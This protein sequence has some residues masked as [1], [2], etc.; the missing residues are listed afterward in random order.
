MPYKSIVTSLLSSTAL[1][2]IKGISIA[3]AISVGASVMFSAPALSDCNN[4]NAVIANGETETVTQNLAEGDNCTIEAGGTIEVGGDD[5]TAILGTNNHTIANDGDITTLGINSSGIVVFD[6][7][8]IA[9]SGSIT[10]QGTNSFGIFAVEDNEISNT[11]TVTTQ[12]DLSAGILANSDNTI[13]NDG[14]I[15]TLGNNGDGIQ[16]ANSN[17]IVNAGTITTQGDDSRGIAAN[18][19][20]IITNMG[21][22]TTQGDLSIGIL[23]GSENAII[24]GNTI[25]TKGNNAFGIFAVNGNE[26]SNTGAITTEGIGSTGILAVVDNVIL[27]AG[28]ITTLAGDGIFVTDNNKITNT[29]TITSLGERSQ[30]IFGGQKNT[31]TNAGAIINQGIQGRGIAANVENIV[32]NTG[33]IT[34]QAERS[35]GIIAF[36]D[37]IVMN[38]GSIATQG[39]QSKGIIA[40]NGNRITNKGKVTSTGED[41]TLIKL[42]SFNTF[43]NGGLLS[44]TSHDGTELEF[45]LVVSD[46][47]NIFNIEQGHLLIGRLGV[48][49]DKSNLSLNFN[50]NVSTVL[51]FEKGEQEV[52]GE[53]LNFA[54]APL[55]ENI[56]TSGFYFA[57]NDTAVAVLDQSGLAQ[58]DEILTDL[59]SGILNTVQ[60]RLAHR[61]SNGALGQ[62]LRK[63]FWAEAFHGVREEKQDGVLQGADHKISGA[64]IGLD[65]K[66]SRTAIVG[67]FGGYAHTNVNIN[68][69]AAET[70]FFN[71]EIKA[72]SYFGGAYV[73]YRSQ[74]GLNIDLAVTAG[75]AEHESRRAVLSNLSLTGVQFPTADYKGTFVSPELTISKT[76]DVS[77]GLGIQPSVRVRYGQMSVDNIIEEGGDDQLVIHERDV[78]F[79][80]LRAQ[81]ALPY[82]HV[83]P[84]GQIL[85]LIPRVGVEARYIN[86]DDVTA[87]LLGDQTIS[88]ASD[89]LGADRQ[90]TGFAGLSGSL[91]ITSSVEAGFDTEAH[92][93][94]DGD[95]AKAEARASVKI[96]F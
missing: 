68:S 33:N 77:K 45:A 59:S 7:N 16:A 29:G 94:E 62:G 19:E 84:E 25:K 39:N 87:S 13:T 89:E 3:Y 43:S 56:T 32:T 83:S 23:A 30:G 41:G 52:L 57:V 26:I 65:G 71:Q 12:G 63:A 42:Q 91:Q 21:N 93:D 58:Q 37:N 54:G 27:N 34:T 76:F 14:T 50:N 35:E 67:A 92:V 82:A 88:I 60:S 78:A 95:F 31:I 69:D 18:N 75:N 44:A 51:T 9:N 6:E 96:K 10:T 66:I 55:A 49:D 85:K 90:V 38:T 2:H 73:G 40:L 80:Q 20:N 36:I 64:I 79:T 81:L 8:I 15:I 24:N 4:G 70:G 1:T 22:I 17:V 47:A 28:T 48:A 86:N 72:D 74:N 5:D 61:N 46:E 11:G 53:P